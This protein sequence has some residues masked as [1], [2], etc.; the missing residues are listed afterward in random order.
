MRAIQTS[1]LL[2]AL[3]I[4]SAA[5]LS[6]MTTTEKQSSAFDHAAFH[7]SDLARSAAFYQKLGIRRIEDPFKDDRHVWFSIGPQQ[8]LHLIAGGT[9]NLKSDIQ[10]HIAIRV[11]SLSALIARLDQ[12][13]IR[14][15]NS[16]GEPQKLSTRPDG[17]MQIYVQDP[18]GYWLELNDAKR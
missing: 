5:N 2:A 10:V 15:Y 17:V 6:W 18:D 11:P 12:L 3:T 7:V 1:I 13:N 8:Q 16:K 9:E 4:S 14:Y